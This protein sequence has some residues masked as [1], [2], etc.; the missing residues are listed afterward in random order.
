M[1]A[2]LVIGADSF[3]GS[4]LA[5]ILLERDHCVY[6]STRRKDT[7]NSKRIYFDFLDG[8]PLELPS[9]VGHTY[10]VA[11]ATNYGLCANDPKARLI[12]TVYTPRLVAFLLER[13]MFVTFVSS[14]S[15]FGGDTPW[16]HEDAKPH[17]QIPYAIQ[18]CEAEKSIL[19][20]ARVLGL[21]HRLAIVRLT[22]VLDVETPPLSAWLEAWRQ[23]KAVCPFMDLI[24]APV[25]RRFAGE[26]LAIISEKK[27][28]GFLHVSGADNVNYL[29]LAKLLARTLG[30]SSHLIK[31]TTATAMGVEIPFKPRYSGIGMER[32]T[33]YTGLRP[34]S[35][36]DVARDLS[37][38]FVTGQKG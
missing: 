15:V 9:G 14:N 27:V 10:V 16:P 8:Q 33:V 37:N 24:F 38:S 13:G 28:A 23:G 35:L 3:V 19:G 5:A 1:N 7:L 18:K 26:A 32:T 21:E 30:V 2:H 29:D 36:A 17:P 25:S 20:A 34:Q 22:K 6:A 4:S 11:A 12:N 31:P